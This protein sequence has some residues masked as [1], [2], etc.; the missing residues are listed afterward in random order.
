M[1]KIPISTHN[2]KLCYF[3]QLFIISHSSLLPLYMLWLE[4]MTQSNLKLNSTY[5]TQES[6]Q[7]PIAPQ[8]LVKKPKCDFSKGKIVEFAAPSKALLLIGRE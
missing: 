2:T 3:C 5:C 7:I 1:N 4:D 8:K 6:G